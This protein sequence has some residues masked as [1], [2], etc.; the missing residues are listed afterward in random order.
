MCPLF[1]RGLTGLAEK[2]TAET[3]KLKGEGET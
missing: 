1:L 2:E 3:L